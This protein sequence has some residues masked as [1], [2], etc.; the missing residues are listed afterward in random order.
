MSNTSQLHRLHQKFAQFRRDSKGQV[1]VI[2]GLAILPVMGFV[3]TAVDYSRGVS[4]LNSLNAAADSAA[5]N[6]VAKGRVTH[7]APDAATVRQY[8]DAS[9]ALGANV[10]INSFAVTNTNTVTTLNVQVAYTAQVDTT[11]MNVFGIHQL[12]LGLPVR[13]LRTVKLQREREWLR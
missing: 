3:G 12:H 13:R 2:L 1:A 8:F 10:Q 5:L 6:A 7:V 9:G 4:A 11:F